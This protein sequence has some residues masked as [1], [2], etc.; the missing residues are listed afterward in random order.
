MTDERIDV[1]TAGF[2]LF[3]LG[4]HFFGED[5]E[6]FEIGFEENFPRICFLLAENFPR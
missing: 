5:E 1:D 3:S 2:C 4:K 6:K